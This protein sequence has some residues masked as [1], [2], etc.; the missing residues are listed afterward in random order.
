[1]S[2]VSGDGKVSVG[3]NEGEDDTL[4][5]G[6]SDSGSD[7]SGVSVGGNEGGDDKGSF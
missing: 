6:S 7:A 1:M 5:V 3:N 2:G 4:S